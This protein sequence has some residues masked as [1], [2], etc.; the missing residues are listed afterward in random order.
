[1]KRW[2]ALSAVCALVLAAPASA[3]T[4]SSNYRAHIKLAKLVKHLQAL[5]DIADAN[6]GTRASGTPGYTASVNYVADKLRDKGF[7]VTIQDFE[8]PFFQELAAPKLEQ[9]APTAKPYVETV[10]FFTMTYS[11]SGDVTRNVQAVDTNATPNPEATSTS[12]CEA[13]DFTGFVAGRI[14][15]M[16]RGTCTFRVKALNAQ[17]AGASAAVIFNRG[18]GDNGPINGTL[19]SPGVTIPAVGTSFAVGQELYSAGSSV[20]AHVFT[21]TISETRTTSNVLAE[22]PGGRSDKVVVAGAHLDSVT[23]GPGVTDNG[24]G[25]AT[26]LEAALNLNSSVNMFKTGGNGLKNK[27]VFAFWGAEELNL[28]GSGYYVS[29]LTPAQR[30]AITININ[31]DMLSSSNGVYFVQDGDGAHTVPPGPV[32]P[33]RSAELEHVLTSYLESQGLPWVAR[34]YD[35]R[36]DYMSFVNAGIG[37]GGLTTGSDQVKTP[38]QAALFGGIA[39]LTMHPTYHTAADRLDQVNMKSLDDMSDATAHAILWFAMDGE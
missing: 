2:I 5:Q 17:A 6:D 21:S 9:V 28:L 32:R 13:S 1:M 18:G 12:G 23:A 7:N 16:Q 31:V 8:F 27:V 33:G 30:A 3:A 11:G 37:A 38:E 39:G 24:S 22:T 35:G 14:A 29:Q 34:P 19:G 25:V 15:L 26:M 4:D 20:V 36:S 10:D